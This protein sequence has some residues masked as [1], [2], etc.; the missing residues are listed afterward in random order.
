MSDIWWPI[1]SKILFLLSIQKKFKIFFILLEGGCTSYHF[2]N[3]QSDIKSKILLEILNKVSFSQC[4]IFSNY[5]VTAEAI[6]EKLNSNGS[7]TS[8][9][10]K[11]EKS[12][13][14]EF[15]AFR[16]QYLLHSELH[17]FSPSEEKKLL[18]LALEPILEPF[19][20]AVPN[21]LSLTTKDI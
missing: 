12:E 17:A 11:L 8:N 16:K 7:G 20:R 21:W 5:F 14:L 15:R 13:P 4:L 9:I 6:C 19:M 1:Y 10:P 2:S 3:I 18:F